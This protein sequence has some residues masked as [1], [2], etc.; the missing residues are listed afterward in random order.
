M[1]H[2]AS[3]SSARPRLAR[4]T[5]PRAAAVILLAFWLLLVVATWNQSATVDEP[6]TPAAGITHW[7]LN[8]YRLDPENGNLTHRLAALPLLGTQLPSLTDSAWRNPE[9]SD[10][11]DAWFHLPGNVPENIL[12]RGRAVMALAAVGLAALV[13]LGSRSLF[14]PVGGMLSLLLCVLNPTLLANGALMTADTLAALFFLAATWAWW[15]LLQRITPGRLALSTLATGGLLMSKM[16]GVLIAPISLLLLGARLAEGRPLEFAGWKW[17]GELGPRSRQAAALLAA[18]AVQFVVVWVMLWGCYGFRYA[19]MAPGQPSTRGSEYLWQ[20]VLAP[21]SLPEALE[22]LALPSDVLRRAR[23]VVDKYALPLEGASALTEVARVELGREVLTPLQSAALE[24]RMAA[25]PPQGMARLS[26]LLARHEVLP[27]AYLLGSLHALRSAHMRWAFLNG[28]SYHLGRPGYFPYTFAV[29]TPLP[30]LGL[31]GLAAAAAWVGWRREILRGALPF[32]VLFLCYG[33]STVTSG[34]NIGHR[35]I[36]TLY[37]PLFILAGAAGGWLGEGRARRAGGAVLLLLGAQALEIAARFPNYLA[38]FNGIV[39]PARAYRH[40]VDSS[41]DWG[42]DLPGVRKY[43]DAHAAEGPFH[44]AYFGAGDP[45]TYGIEAN[46]LPSQPG[47]FRTGRG[48]VVVAPIAAVTPT[49]AE[50]EALARRYPAYSVVAAGTNDD[51]QTRAVLL[52]RPEV[53]KLTGGTYLISATLLQLP[54]WGEFQEANYQELRQHTRPLVSPAT[55]E[56]YFAALSRY[57]V[58]PAGE[59]LAE[60]ETVRMNRLAAFLRGYT[61]DASVG[62]SIL[63]YKMTDADI[64]QALEGPPPYRRSEQDRTL[65]AGP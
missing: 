23:A 24:A 42:Q 49:A 48:P 26:T 47:R 8:D 35:H 2:P 60:F 44:L 57:G 33:L 3:A 11:G 56:E 25:A 5:S 53:W 19:M 65:S 34:L 1:E 41:L 17:R 4:L 52:R 10:F 14:G 64:D 37:P 63:A 31:L 61:P 51:G 6:G 20:A 28:E 55:T 50:R 40:L 54:I 21:P 16:S 27:E 38:Y 36:L 9:P 18:G 46:F 29:K 58:K 15:R 30:F 39:S 32:A 45:Q 43:L 12:R 7:K 22:E 59:L 62:H 13:W